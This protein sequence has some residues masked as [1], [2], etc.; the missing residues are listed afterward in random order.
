MHQGQS[1]Q[2]R[3][4]GIGRNMG[5]GRNAIQ[6]EQ[7]IKKA[8]LEGGVEIAVNR[9]P[10]N[11]DEKRPLQQGGVYKEAERG[12]KDKKKATVNTWSKM[13]AWWVMANV[14]LPDNRCGSPCGFSLRSQKGLRTTGPRLP[15]RPQTDRNWAGSLGTQR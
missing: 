12:E 7:F 8:K 10:K 4:G 6:P 2:R 14:A 11:P 15:S 13:S 3:G 1:G 5:A 9:G